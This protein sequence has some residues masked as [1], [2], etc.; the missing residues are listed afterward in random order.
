MQLL[1]IKAVAEDV[2]LGVF[3]YWLELVAEDL[4]SVL[5]QDAVGLEFGYRFVQ[6]LVGGVGVVHPS[7]A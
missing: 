3:L 4:G 6:V 1:D 2:G 7:Q 5:D